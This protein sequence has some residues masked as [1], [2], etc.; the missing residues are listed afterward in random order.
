MCRRK[1]GFISAI[2]IFMCINPL[3]AS[4][5]CSYVV[6]LIPVVQKLVPC[7]PRECSWSLGPVGPVEQV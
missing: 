1:F 5:K 3:Y 7:F 6:H 4:Y 2:F